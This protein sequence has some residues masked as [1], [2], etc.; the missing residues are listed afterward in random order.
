MSDE[1]I[2]VIVEQLVGMFKSEA[3]TMSEAAICDDEYK[4]EAH[5]IM[6]SS[7]ARAAKQ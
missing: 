4:D 3:E 5:E 2:T 6:V 7:L 1:T